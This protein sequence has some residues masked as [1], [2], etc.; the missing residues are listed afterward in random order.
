[1]YNI[2]HLLVCTRDIHIRHLVPL[3]SIYENHIVYAIALIT[4]LY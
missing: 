3:Y 2:N 1:M 4:F